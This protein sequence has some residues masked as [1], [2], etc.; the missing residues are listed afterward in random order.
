MYVN[1]VKLQNRKLKIKDESKEY[2][3][4]LL[5]ENDVFRIKAGRR[6]LLDSIVLSGVFETIKSTVDGNDE[7]MT[8]GKG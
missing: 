8:L 7:T 4:G 5:E 1:F 3:V 6:L 2:E